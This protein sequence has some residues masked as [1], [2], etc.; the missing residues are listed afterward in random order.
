MR[1]G[2]GTLLAPEAVRLAPGHSERSAPRA[3]CHS[4]RSAQRAVEESALSA[5]GGIA[6]HA[7]ARRTAGGPSKT[8]APRPAECRPRSLFSWGCGW[9]GPM[10]RRALLDPE[11]SDPCRFRSDRP[12]RSA[13]RCSIRRS[14]RPEAGLGALSVSPR[15]RVNPRLVAHQS[16]AQIDAPRAAEHRWRR[17][18]TSHQR[19]NARSPR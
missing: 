7:G 19:S 8:F 14:K 15:L 5:R 6:Y 2:L 9:R 18:P 16:H 10:R 4:E 13:F 17:R 12:S 1:N 3:P 11:R